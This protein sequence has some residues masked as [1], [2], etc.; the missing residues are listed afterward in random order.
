MMDQ[1]VMT[2]APTQAPQ[3]SDGSDTVYFWYLHIYDFM[4][5]TNNKCYL[6][7]FIVAMMPTPAPTQV[8][9]INDGGIVATGTMTQEDVPATQVPQT[10]ESSDTIHFL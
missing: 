7:G 3:T 8:S 10:N 2:S 1:E 5:S 9:Q 6:A 4:K